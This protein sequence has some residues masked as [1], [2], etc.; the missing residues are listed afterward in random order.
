MNQRLHNKI[1]QLKIFNKKRMGKI[2][3]DKTAKK[4]SQSPKQKNQENQQFAF[5]LFRTKIEVKMLNMTD[6]LK[7]LTSS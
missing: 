5:L 3:K 4:T 1:Q 6:L 7:H 2:V